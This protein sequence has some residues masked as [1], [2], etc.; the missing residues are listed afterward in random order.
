MSD[1]ISRQDALEAIEA[2]REGFD[3]NGQYDERTGAE[4]AKAVI[5]ELPSAK[6]SSKLLA[7]ITVQYPEVLCAN[8]KHCEHRNNDEPYCH[9][10]AMVVT[11]DYF[12]ADGEE[13]E[14]MP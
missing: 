8:C 14:W 10:H 2:L 12:C 13:G 4:W 11:P 5:N 6:P 9:H 1:L 7:N 3:E